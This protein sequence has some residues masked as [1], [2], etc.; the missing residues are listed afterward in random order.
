LLS[1]LFEAHLDDCALIGSGLEE[2][3]FG[4][5]GVAF[6]VFEGGE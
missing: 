3:G 1:L 5:E 4:E 6:G 2:A